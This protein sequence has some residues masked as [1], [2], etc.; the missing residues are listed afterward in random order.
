MVGLRIGPTAS[1]RVPGASDSNGLLS[2]LHGMEAIEAGD[3]RKQ[4]DKAKLDLGQKITSLGKE[5]ARLASQVAE[6]GPS[7][8]LKVAEL[9][10]KFEECQ[11]L[12]ELAETSG[13]N[14]LATACELHQEQ[15]ELKEARSEY[16]TEYSQAEAI[17]KAGAALEAA[18]QELAQL[19][20]NAAG[21]SKS[22][23]S[24]KAEAEDAADIEFD[25]AFYSQIATENNAEWLT[26]YQPCQQGEFTSFIPNERNKGIVLET[27][28]PHWHTMEQPAL[29]DAVLGYVDW[30]KDHAQPTSR[31]HNFKTVL[32]HLIMQCATKDACATLAKPLFVLLTQF[33]KESTS[34]S[35]T[36]CPLPPGWISF[37][38]YRSGMSNVLK[39][40]HRAHVAL[41]KR[42]GR[43]EPRYAGPPYSRWTDRFCASTKQHVS[44]WAIFFGAYK[45]HSE[46]QRRA[47][48]V[49]P[50]VMT[51]FRGLISPGDATL[52]A[53]FDNMQK[54]M[55][56]SVSACASGAMPAGDGTDEPTCDA[57]LAYANMETTQHADGI[58]AQ[59]MDA[60]AQPAALPSTYED[61][62]GALDSAFLEVDTRVDLQSDL[63]NSRGASSGQTPRT[64]PDEEDGTALV[65][66]DLIARY[67][68]D[69]GIRTPPH[70]PEGTLRSS[71]SPLRGDDVLNL[72]P[73]ASP[74][75]SAATDDAMAPLP[76]TILNDAFRQEA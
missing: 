73:D 12:Q 24:L 50:E 37:K 19:T 14:V 30:I 35:A 60:V 41:R 54:V 67:A 7:H 70:S 49:A 5:R 72:L 52:Y 65:D 2:L 75:R 56:G 48:G 55:S 32:S 3:K 68:Q 47:K 76:V 61:L 53:D 9:I 23:R 59:Q 21:S 57:F 45:N 13:S 11:R 58:P 16:L 25:E 20:A 64:Q 15:D 40:W 51:L 27:V 71:D 63:R 36:V 17:F 33:T 62:A 29:K 69:G 8:V 4:S 66:L 46:F 31:M 34:R 22:A 74:G 26:Y 39:D 18:E 44:A 10:R 1:Q 43:L 6:R 28:T 38:T 42:D